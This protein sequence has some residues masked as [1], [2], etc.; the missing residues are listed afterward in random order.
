[1]WVGNRP[2]IRPTALLVRRSDDPNPWWLVRGGE[3]AILSQGF[4]T[5]TAARAL[6]KTRGWRVVRQPDC[7]E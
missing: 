7:D 2:M 3:Q 1:V 6:G 4:R 5:A